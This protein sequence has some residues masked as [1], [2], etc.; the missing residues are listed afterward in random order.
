MAAKKSSD[1]KGNLKQNQQFLRSLLIWLLGF[2]IIVQLIAL[3][4]QG[5]KNKE[6]LSYSQFYNILK[7]NN[8]NPL[9]YSVKKTENK[10]EGQFLPIEQN[11][12]FQVYVPDEDKELIELLKNNVEK[13]EVEPPQTF[14]AGLFYSLAPIVLFIFFL[15]YFAYRGSKQVG[16][17]LWSFGK[18]RG[19]LIEQGKTRV[20]FEDVAG[21]DE[22]K[23]E[24]KEVIEFLKDPKRFQRLGG[25]IPKGVLL[26]GPPGCGKTLIA[27]AVAGEADVPFFSISGSDFVEL[28][29]GVGASRVRDL[30]DQAKKAAKIS[31][32]GCI[33]FIDEID[34]VGRQRF[35]GI[36]GGHDEREQTLNQLLVDMDGFA[37]NE[38]IIVMA[39]TNRPDVLDPAL[40]RP[41]RFDRHIVI[42][43]P[44]IKG[45]EEILKVHTKTIKLDQDVNLNSIARQTPGFS[46]AD[47]ANLCNEGALLAARKNKDTVT[48]EEVEESIERVMAGPQRKSRII[49]KKEKEIVS[50]HESGH[51]LLSVVL[52]DVDPLHKVSIIPRGVGALGYTMQLPLQDRYLLTEQEL[53]SRICV[54]LAGRVSEILVL[55]E[56]STGAEND[57]RIATDLA[58]KMVT[59][60]GM[61]K[62]LGSLT[63][64]K[65]D[66]PVFLGK[67]LIDQKDYSE[68]T[69]R[70]IDEE[71]KRIIDEA[72]SKSEN[73]VKDNLG[74]LKLLA[75][76]LLEKEILDAEEVKKILGFE[77]KNDDNASPPS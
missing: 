14:W 65:R 73:I 69:A 21:V 23:E 39:A 19:K 3:F 57:L 55:G 13:F 17:S 27:K 26:V 49:S 51:A 5:L 43:R 32:K 66:G 29:V 34:A 46:G 76:A 70:I 16:G 53:F 45:R 18:V 10:I 77:N 64:G 1:N 56:I 62:R 59:D 54:L 71:L 9:I 74:K 31:T 36:G 8:E 15:W 44:D 20:T 58:R 52:S 24:L 25:K 48:R 42:D 61:S 75:A 40:L 7:N 28:F 50:I 33:V 41:G 22:A 67:D 60:F 12:W 37:P 4:S 6:T 72:Y 11:K 68:E 35:A 30:F 63:L 47:L 38:G 2:F